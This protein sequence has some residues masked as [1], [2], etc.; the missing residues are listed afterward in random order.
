M[1]TLSSVCDGDAAVPHGYN[2]RLQ[3]R[4]TG[5]GEGAGTD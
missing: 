1:D 3:W 5:E 4:R 2:S